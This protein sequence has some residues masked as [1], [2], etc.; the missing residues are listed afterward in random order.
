[1]KKLLVK[2]IGP[3][4]PGQ[5]HYRIPGA[6]PFLPAESGTHPKPAPLVPGIVVAIGPWVEVEVVDDRHEE[7]LRQDHF[8]AF[9]EPEPPPAAE[10]DAPAS[11]A[12]EAPETQADTS[13]KGKKA[14]R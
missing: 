5:K 14:K 1:M 8:L 7:I 6:H 11:P 13:P 3:V 12:E 2:V 9:K 4:L 10:A